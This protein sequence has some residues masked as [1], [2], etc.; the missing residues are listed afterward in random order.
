[1][2]DRQ[3]VKLGTVDH[4]VRD[5]WSGEVRKFMVRRKDPEEDLFIS[6]NDVE[7]ADKGQ[8]KLKV[9]QEE[10]IRR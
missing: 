9:T 1:M 8:I 4:I 3:G 2:V 5:T 7:K 6:L 10:L